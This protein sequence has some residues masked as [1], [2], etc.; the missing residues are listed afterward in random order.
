MARWASVAVERSTKAYP[1]GR[2][3]LGL[4]G[5]EVDSLIK[6]VSKVGLDLRSEGWREEY[7]GTYTRKPLKKSFKSP[8][9]VA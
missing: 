2:A 5:M 4:V 8:S 9:V 3:V 6:V 1:T 7:S